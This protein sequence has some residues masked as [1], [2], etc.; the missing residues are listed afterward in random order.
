[1]AERALSFLTALSVTTTA[2][3]DRCRPI[4][5]CREGHSLR[6]CLVGVAVDGYCLVGVLGVGE[7]TGGDWV[8]V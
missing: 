1:M 2:R 8:L 5:T 7:E 3:L 6:H 4:L